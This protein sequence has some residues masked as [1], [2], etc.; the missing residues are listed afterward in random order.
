MTDRGPSRGNCLE[1]LL[2]PVARAA[3]VDGM[4]G[5]NRPSWKSRYKV[6]PVRSA[7]FAKGLHRL[8][9]EVRDGR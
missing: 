6:E 9:T 2:Q 5:S 4:E 3:V 7:S 8:P 1:C